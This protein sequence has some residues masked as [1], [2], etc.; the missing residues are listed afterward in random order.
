MMDLFQNL[1][2][3]G[4]DA[5]Q[6]APTDMSQIKVQPQALEPASSISAANAQLD[7]NKAPQGGG[8][9]WASLGLMAAS[10]LAGSRGSQQQKPMQPGPSAPR[11]S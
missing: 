7:F 4:G 3:R 8:T 5:A 11:I 2:A 1:W 6:A 9:D 10:Q